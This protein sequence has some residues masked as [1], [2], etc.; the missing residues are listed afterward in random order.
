MPWWEFQLYHGG[1]KIYVCHLLADQMLTRLNGLTKI[2]TY[3]QQ[4]LLRNALDHPSTS[5]QNGSVRLLTRTQKPFTQPIFPMPP[6]RNSRQASLAK[7][8]W[9]LLALIFILAVTLI[10][11]GTYKTKPFDLL[12]DTPDLHLPLSH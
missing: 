3:S 12:K 4:P 11:I 10:T 1:E 6:L 7:I 8:N 2:V 9:V 5:L